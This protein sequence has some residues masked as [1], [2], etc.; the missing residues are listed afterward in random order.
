VATNT[1]LFEHM[2]DDMDINAGVI[3]QG[4]TVEDVGRTIFDKIIAVASG[5]RTKS[6]L[7]GIG[8]EEFNPWMTGA[9]L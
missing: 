4:A 1:P 5:E 2:N 6:E 8:D 3:L 9:V 7:H